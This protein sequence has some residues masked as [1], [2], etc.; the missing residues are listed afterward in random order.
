MRSIQKTITMN[1]YETSLHII[2][3]GRA[4][5]GAYVASPNFSQYG[6]SWLRDGA[7]IAYAMDCVG[8]HNSARAFYEWVGRV[9][10]SQRERIEALLDKLANGQTTEETDYLPTRFTLDGSIDPHDPWPNFQLDGYGT[11]LWGLAAHTQQTDSRLWKSL[12]PAVELTVRYLAALWKSPNYD[13]WEEHRQHIHISTLAA[14]FGGL[15]A[16]ENLESSKVPA[17]LTQEIRQFV[18]QNG[19]APEGHFMK[20]LG[21]SE[22]DASLLWL[23]VPYQ[24]VSVSDPIF[25]NTVKKIEMELRSGGVYRYKADTYYGGGEWI[26]LTAWLGWVYAELGVT[27]EAR[28]L[29]AWIEAQAASNGELPEQVSDHLLDARYFPEWE[30]RWGKIACPLLWSHAMYLILKTKLDKTR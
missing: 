21:N 15:S 25:V 22:V 11:W 3:A 27:E 14:V 29:L 28:L 26:L 5:S 6:Y 7:W 2:R 16:I 13:C 10:L 1:L 17:G 9:V 24:L 20:F 23:A 18:F 8:Q 19:V 30:Q 4:A 12:L